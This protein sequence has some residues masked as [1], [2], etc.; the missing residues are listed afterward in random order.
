MI[1]LFKK[2]LPVGTNTDVTNEIKAVADGILVPIEKVPDETFSQKMLGDGVAIDLQTD[3][4]VAPANGTITMIFP[5]LHAFGLS[6]E[7]GIEILVHIGLNTVAL[8]GKGFKQYINTGVPVKKGDRIIKVNRKFLIDGG[9]NPITM[10]IFTQTGGLQ[11]NYTKN[12][13]VYGG[14]STVATF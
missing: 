2:F 7:N 13:K 4:I 6:M 11:L 14:R 12:G 3:I 9:Y 10:M 8:N 5:T 1:E